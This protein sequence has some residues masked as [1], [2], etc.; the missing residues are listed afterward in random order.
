MQG[1]PLDS[2]LECEGLRLAVQSCCASCSDLRLKCETPLVEIAPAPRGV[3]GFTPDRVSCEVPTTRHKPAR[4]APAPLASCCCSVVP[5]S[6]HGGRCHHRLSRTAGRCSAPACALHSPSHGQHSQDQV[7][8]HSTTHACG[9]CSESA[10]LSLLWSERALLAAAG[11]DPALLLCPCYR[12]CSADP[13][14]ALGQ[15]EAAARRAAAARARATPNPAFSGRSVQRWPRKT[16]TSAP[17]RLTPLAPSGKG[18]CCTASSNPA[19]ESTDER[20]LMM[21]VLLLDVLL[22]DD[23]TAPCVRECGARRR[24]PTMGVSKR[25]TRNPNLRSPTAG[26]HVLTMYMVMLAVLMRIVLLLLV[27]AARAGRHAAWLCSF[28]MFRLLHGMSG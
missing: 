7:G 27:H 3:L 6:L 28:R 22:A 11:A 25:H 24:P 21:Y 4:A 5:K 14:G 20:G 17:A 13:R 9:G 16:R 10:P 23:S 12:V 2:P 15:C 18:F 8:Q 26:K 1:C 19:S